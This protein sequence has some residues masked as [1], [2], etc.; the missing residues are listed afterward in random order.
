MILDEA[1]YCWPV[2]TV[3]CFYGPGYQCR[4]SGRSCIMYTIWHVN[5][6]RPLDNNTAYSHRTW[7]PQYDFSS[8]VTTSTPPHWRRHC[9]KWKQ[10]Q[11]S[12]PEAWTWI[13]TWKP[14]V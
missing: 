14:T 9:R 7:A 10:K 12:T 13:G 5:T 1:S 11:A 6:W 2:W 3:R 8:Y 4:I